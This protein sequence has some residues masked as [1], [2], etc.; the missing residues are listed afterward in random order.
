M[1]LVQTDAEVYP[2]GDSPRYRCVNS[3]DPLLLKVNHNLSVGLITLLVVEGMLCVR[4][5]VIDV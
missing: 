1:E 2:E 3:D 4:H 5:P